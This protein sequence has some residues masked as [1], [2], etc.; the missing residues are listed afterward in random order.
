MHLTYL[1]DNT[2]S[3]PFYKKH[4]EKITQTKEANFSH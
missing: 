3:G 4:F 2:S 1:L